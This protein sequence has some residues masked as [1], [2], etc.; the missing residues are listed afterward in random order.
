MSFW[1]HIKDKVAFDQP[2]MR[3]ELLERESGEPRHLFGWEDIPAQQEEAYDPCPDTLAEVK[4]KLGKTFRTD[5]N[6]DVIFKRF[7]AGAEKIML[8]YM[9]GMADADLISD[10][11]IKPLLK[12]DETEDVGL[13][14]LREHYVEISEDETSD[15]LTKIKQAIMDGMT[16]LFME[17]ENQALILETR[18]YEK[19]SVSSAENEKVVRGPKEG[20]VESIRT[21]ITLVRR[22]IK[23]NDLVVERRSSGGDNNT[24][25]AILYRD[26]V[27]NRS[28]IEEVKRRLAK[29]NIRSMFSTGVLEQL[30][31]DCPSSPLPQTLATERPDRTANYIMRGSVALIADGSPFAIIIPITL[32]SLMSSP[33][34]V[35]LR[36]PLGD[37]IRIVRY[38]GVLLSLLL[39]GYFI[40][41]ALYHQGLLS[42]EVLNTV[43][44]SRQMVFLPIAAEMVMLL[45][46]FQLI[47]EA[48]MRVPGSIGQAIGIIGGL[49][50]GQAAVAA[51]LA[52]SVILIVVA[53][54]GL[55]NFCIP[56]HSSQIAASYFRIAFVIA[57][58]LAGL[59]GLTCAFVIFIA[60][61]ANLKSF[62][63]PFLAP[64]APKTY[65]KRPFILRGR[66]GMHHRAEDYMNTHSDTLKKKKDNSVKA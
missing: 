52:S 26:G 62:G 41:L 18:G 54:S 43:I 25:I 19:R 36:K 24:Q 12:I 8:V 47:R 32:A 16:I 55:G 49:I 20:F 58:W 22:I 38:I 50:L 15:D 57:A 11:I 21:N 1:K 10:F 31:E 37:V 64:Y 56:D 35:Y 13:N 46:V 61:L 27:T 14:D 44:Q 6:K 42:N 45:L 66:I 51:N 9:N 23:S 59:L 3:F 40:A 34:D 53:V 33:E 30:I 5:I 2:D 65:N 17:G 28:L 63:V 4:D 7:T 29:I 60:Y 39:P 48:G